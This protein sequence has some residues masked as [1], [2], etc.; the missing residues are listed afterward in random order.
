MLNYQYLY[1]VKFNFEIILNDN[2]G[3][4]I[5]LDN[6]YYWEGEIY[7]SSNNKSITQKEIGI[8]PFDFAIKYISDNFDD[9]Y[10]AMPTNINVNSC[11]IIDKVYTY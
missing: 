5:I 1:K 9:K 4:D 11:E 3:N 2:G 10:K 8:Y 6:D 7:F